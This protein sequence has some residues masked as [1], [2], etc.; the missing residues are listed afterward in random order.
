MDRVTFRQIS[1]VT[2]GVAMIDPTEKPFHYLIPP[3]KEKC[4]N[5]SEFSQL[6]Q[7]YKLLYSNSS[8]ISISHF[9]YECKQMLI[10][11][12]EFISSNSRSQRSP[13]IV[14]HWPNISGIDPH[15]NAP[16]RIG[17]AVSYFRHQITLSRDPLNQNDVSTV[18]HAIAR[19]KWYMDHPH[20]DFIH[21]SIIICATT[22]INFDS[23]SEANF[24]PIS[25][26]AGRAAD[27][28][29]KFMFDYG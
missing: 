24:I 8:I 3:L 25:R 2:C 29:R 9:Y 17:L 5:D 12:E 16:L 11:N 15:G 14:A 26:I 13:A 22:N 21:P 23:V 28:K 10:N 18:F 20:C 27:A 1:H 19:V 6:Q 7:M 4:F